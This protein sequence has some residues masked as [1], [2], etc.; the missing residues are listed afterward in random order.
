VRQRKSSPESGSR[1]HGNDAAV[2]A[3]K[4]DGWTELFP[5]RAS[6]VRG[7]E[8]GS[9]RGVMVCNGGAC[10]SVEGRNGNGR[11]PEHRTRDL[12]L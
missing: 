11:F 9:P 4:R 7:Q 1:R 10:T 8:A 6:S 5:C 2:T 12:A 3:G